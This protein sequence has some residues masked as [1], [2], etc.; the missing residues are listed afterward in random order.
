MIDLDVLRAAL[1]EVLDDG[2]DDLCWFVPPAQLAEVRAE[3]AVTEA[4]PAEYAPVW[5]AALLQALVDPPA[6]PN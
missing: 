1:A 2:A 6:L 3:P 4:E 5:A